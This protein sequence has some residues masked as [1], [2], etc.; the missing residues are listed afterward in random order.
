M[1]KFA[2]HKQPM[3]KDHIV[4]SL[5]SLSWSLPEVRRWCND[6]WVFR[7]RGPRSSVKEFRYALSIWKTSQIGRKTF[8]KV[9]VLNNFNMTNRDPK[10]WP[11]LYIFKNYLFSL[12]SWNVISWMSRR[13]VI[14]K[15]LIPLGF[16]LEK[17]IK[18][19]TFGD[20]SLNFWCLL[21]FPQNNEYFLTN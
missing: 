17:K 10:K 8:S 1:L 14:P 6:D 5:R 21:P 2:N 16:Q 12:C 20:S 11:S 4:N 3:K 15:Y 13:N 18:K 7:G 19:N 9:T